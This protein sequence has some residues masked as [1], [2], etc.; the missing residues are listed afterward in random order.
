MAK[1]SVI[2]RSICLPKTLDA[3]VVKR[4]KDSAKPMG[5][6]PNYSGALAELIVQQHA[7]ELKKAA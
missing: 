5:K 6:E 2:K 4:A 1:K 3:F 7:A